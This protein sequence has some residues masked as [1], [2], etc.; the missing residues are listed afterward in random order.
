MVSTVADGLV[1]EKFKSTDDFIERLTTAFLTEH[2]KNVMAGAL[3]DVSGRL[4]ASP[5]IAEV[6]AR[7]RDITSR[8]A[9]DVQREYEDLLTMAI[10]ARLL[11]LGSE[12]R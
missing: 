12:T 7:L 3:I 8:E 9:A 6:E 11:K 5:N 2:G 4:D 10:G 1:G